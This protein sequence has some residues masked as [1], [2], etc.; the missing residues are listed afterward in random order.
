MQESGPAGGWPARRGPRQREQRS[1][2]P[3]GRRVFG[4]AIRGYMRRGFHPDQ[5]TEDMKLATAYL[6]QVGMA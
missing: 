6:A 5:E 1:P 3:L 2:Q 4:S